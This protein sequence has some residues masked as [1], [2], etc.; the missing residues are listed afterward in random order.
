MNIVIFSRV[1]TE[2]EIGQSLQFMAEGELLFPYFK[3]SE[4][5]K[6]LSILEESGKKFGDKIRGLLLSLVEGEGD[7]HLAWNE[8]VFI[9]KHS[10]DKQHQKDENL[11]YAYALCISHGVRD[12]GEL[13][14]YVG[15]LLENNCD[16]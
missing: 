5:S 15:S 3:G 12:I 9:Y 16:K 14:T 13:Q 11:H 10:K 1:F 6:K 8:V 7:K 2:K 4:A